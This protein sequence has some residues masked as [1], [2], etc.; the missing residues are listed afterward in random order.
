[1]GKIRHFEQ[2]M[3]D[4]CQC[5]ENGYII[6]ILVDFDGTMCN[7]NYPDIGKENE[8]CIEVMCKWAGDFNVGWILNTMRSKQELDDAVKWIEQ[9]GIKLYGI[10][11]NPTQHTWTTSNKAYGMFSIDD[12]AL[13]CPLIFEEGHRPRVDW[14]KIDEEY[15]PL[16]EKLSKI[17]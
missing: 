10:G 4:I 9:R 13:G 17:K 7:H 15:S 6:P 11:K 2:E 8:H 14:K 3:S 5:D 12:N 1:M 16:I